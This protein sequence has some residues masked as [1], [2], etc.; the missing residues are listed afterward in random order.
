MED[1]SCFGSWVEDQFPSSALYVHCAAEMSNWRFR[2]DYTRVTCR[3]ESGLESLLDSRRYVRNRLGSSCQTLDR[4]AIW[5]YR[6]GALCPW[7][8]R[9]LHL[10]LFRSFD[11]R[12]ARSSEWFTGRRARIEVGNPFQAAAGSL[13]AEFS[14]LPHNHLISIGADRVLFLGLLLDSCKHI[15]KMSPN[16]LRVRRLFPDLTT[17]TP[18]VGEDRPDGD[19]I[20]L[21]RPVGMIGAVSVE[22]MGD[23]EP[24]NLAIRRFR[25]MRMRVTCFAA[26][27]A[28]E[29]AGSAAI[30][31]AVRHLTPL[32]SA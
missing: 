3:G 13:F 12:I 4:M 21:R 29:P 30:R 25:C 19:L 28:V 20:T 2:G 15:Q 5:P 17:F 9:T 23:R 10:G 24:P 31:A 8:A 14:E 16:L 11:E 1:D 6:L 7:F 18:W 32:P 22:G 27:L 26:I